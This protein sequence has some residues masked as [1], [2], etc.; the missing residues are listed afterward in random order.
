MCFSYKF[1]LTGTANLS[2]DIQEK[3]TEI[4]KARKI[5]SKLIFSELKRVEDEMRLIQKEASDFE[6]YSS[7]ERR[8]LRKKQDNAHEQQARIIRELVDETL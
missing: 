3:A 1:R 4:V 5:I 7:K 6:K 8:G 2:K